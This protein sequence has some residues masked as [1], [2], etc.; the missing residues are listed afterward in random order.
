MPAASNVIYGDQARVRV[1]F[2]SKPRILKSSCHFQFWRLL[3]GHSV[4]NCWSIRLRAQP[5]GS[6]S[7]DRHFVLVPLWSEVRD[8]RPKR[9]VRACAMCYFFIKSQHEGIELL[10]EGHVSQSLICHFIFC[11]SNTQWVAPSRYAS[12]Y[13]FPLSRVMSPCT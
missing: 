11:A 7:A 8:V 4:L 5:T 1:A 10:K 12:T 9:G 2:Y 13:T 6:R 3:S